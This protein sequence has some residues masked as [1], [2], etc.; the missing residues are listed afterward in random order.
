MNGNEQKL[1]PNTASQYCTPHYISY[2]NSFSYTT[3][4]CTSYCTSCGVSY[5][6]HLVPHLILHFILHL[7]L[8]PVLLCRVWDRVYYER[9]A[10]NCSKVMNPGAATLKLV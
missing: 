7:V 3:P 9:Q 6:L 8:H 1:H 4:Y 5:R 2:C 10:D